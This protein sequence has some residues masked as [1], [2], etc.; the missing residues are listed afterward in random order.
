MP[1]RHHS[2]T[3]SWTGWTVK[4][5]RRRMSGGEH[6]QA[7]SVEECVPRDVSP[8]KPAG[9]ASRS[10]SVAGGWDLRGVDT[11]LAGYLLLSGVVPPQTQ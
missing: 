9:R 10:G 7:T 11:L 3:P 6:D 8:N 1:S 2:P 5:K 4:G